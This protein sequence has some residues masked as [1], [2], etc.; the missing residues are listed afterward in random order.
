MTTLFSIV[1]EFLFKCDVC[2]MIVAAELEEQNDLD[3]VQN[4]KM[5]LDC[6][7]GGKCK[8]LRD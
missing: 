5:I 8:V 3:D 6:H 2:S 1:K 4:D 7:C